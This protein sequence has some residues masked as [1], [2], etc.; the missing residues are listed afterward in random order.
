MKEI[1]ISLDSDESNEV[2]WVLAF[3]NIELAEETAAIFYLKNEGI[4]D[5]EIASIKLVSTQKA[6]NAEVHSVLGEP[7]FTRENR[8]KPTNKRLART[9][10]LPQIIAYS[11]DDASDLASLGLLDKI[12]MKEELT[13]YET[14]P[15]VIVSTN[16]AVAITCNS[17]GTVS[18][19][20]NIAEKIEEE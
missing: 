15:E 9:D 16:T 3:D 2:N 7:F 17:T 6:S 8:I 13:Q 10:E 20:I 4:N 11:C 5:I 1:T 19:I 14:Y 12:E 18:G